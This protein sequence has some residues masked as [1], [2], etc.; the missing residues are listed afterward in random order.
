M[1]YIFNVN[2]KLWITFYCMPLSS[3]YKMSYQPV[4]FYSGKLKKIVPFHDPV[5][6]PSFLP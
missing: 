2:I 5:F 4:G 1:N 3:D 6:D